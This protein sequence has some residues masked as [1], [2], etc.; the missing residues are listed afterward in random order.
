LSKPILPGSQI[1]PLKIP[2]LKIAMIESKELPGPT[3]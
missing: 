2:E 1:V 3:N